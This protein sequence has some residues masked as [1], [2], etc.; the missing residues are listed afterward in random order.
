MG[1]STHVLDT[2]KGRPAEGVGI[3]LEDDRGVIARGVTDADG[4]LKLI[5]DPPAAG[6]Y[7]ITFDTGGYDANG[8]FPRVVIEFRVVEARHYHVPLLLSPFGYTTYRG[9]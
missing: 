7:R 5:D 6:T 4:R 8:F 3:T 1:I 2:A 9:S